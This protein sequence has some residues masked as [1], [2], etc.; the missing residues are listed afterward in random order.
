MELNIGKC[1]V[2]H[3]SRKHQPIHYKHQLLGH[4]VKVTNTQ[5]DLGIVLLPDLKWN[6][7]VD[8]TLSKGNRT[9]GFISHEQLIST[10]PKSIPLEIPGTRTVTY[11]N[12]FYARA[13]SVWN[14]LPND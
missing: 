8:I 14:T 11:K 9:L 1:G 3:S 13:P 2:I 10:T 7:Q 6:K 12:S 5:K 4:P